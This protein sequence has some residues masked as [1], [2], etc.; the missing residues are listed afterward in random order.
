MKTTPSTLKQT[1][2]IHA[3]ICL[4]NNLNAFTHILIL[5]VFFFP[6]IYTFLSAPI[7][8]LMMK[9]NVETSSFFN[10]F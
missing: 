8:D 3:K 10:V 1:D 7:F 5:K 9:L 2:S 6:S 4:K